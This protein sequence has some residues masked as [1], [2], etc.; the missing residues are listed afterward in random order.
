MIGNRNRPLAQLNTPKPD[1]MK[2][3]FWVCRYTVPAVK[4]HITCI[5][6]SIPA[7]IM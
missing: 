7:V 6:N 1:R 4:G 2:V 5:N 3:M